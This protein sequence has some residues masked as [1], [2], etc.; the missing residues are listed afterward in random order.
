MS[1]IQGRRDEEIEAEVARIR[2]AVR[3]ATGTVTSPDHAVQVAA[4]PGSVRQVSFTS[5]ISGHSA[6]ELSSIVTETVRSAVRQAEE[7]LAEDPPGI[8]GSSSYAEALGPLPP[9]VAAPEPAR[10]SR[11]ERL[12]ALR[13][14]AGRQLDGYARLQAEI[15]EL[16]V[17]GSAAGGAV[18]V[19]QRQG[20]PPDRIDITDAA[21]RHGAERLGMIVTEALRDATVQLAER[22]SAAVQPI[23]G[24]R[25]EAAEQAGRSPDEW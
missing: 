25:L 5:R 2:H 1:T 16:V 11:V 20:R 8:T 6:A 10:A 7:R 24:G 3:A 19:T 23:A 9:P 17:T 14:R 15:A 18:T 12:E 21:I 13:E 4:G 22:M